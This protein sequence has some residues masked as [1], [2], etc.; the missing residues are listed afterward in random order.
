MIVINHYP[1]I[2]MELPIAESVWGAAA[3][4]LRSGESLYIAMAPPELLCGGREAIYRVAI[5][6][7]YGLPTCLLRNTSR[8]H[9]FEP[10]R[11]HTPNEYLKKNH[12]F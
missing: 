11:L 5:D 3:R 8:S 2:E 4:H 12:I 7:S 9:R 6:F 10:T 1:C